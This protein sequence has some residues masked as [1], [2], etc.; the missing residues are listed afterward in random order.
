MLPKKILFFGTPSLA[1]PTLEALHQDAR[2]TVTGV[3][4]FPDRKVGRKQVLT[5]APL[6]VA[7]QALG[8]PIHEVAN[9]DDLRKVLGQSLKGQGCA[10]SEAEK[11]HPG[12]RTADDAAPEHI[13]KDTAPLPPKDDEPYGNTKPF[14]D[15]A[16]VIAFGMI[17]PPDV[18][19]L[20]PC[21]VLNVHF[22]LLPAYRGATPVQAAVRDGQSISGITLQRMVPALDAGDILWQAPYPIEGKKTSE[23]FTFFAQETAKNLLDVLHG[24]LEGRITPQPQDEAAATFCTTLRRE[25]ALLDTQSLCAREVMQRFLAY[26]IFPGVEIQTQYGRLKLKDISCA[27]LEGAVEL[28]C[29]GG[30]SVYIVRAQ[31]PGKKPAQMEDIVRGYPGILS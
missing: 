19:E 21:G 17:F 31:L 5:P 30:G 6:K 27:P 22:S 4:V 20:L 25:D 10:R 14:P 2:F 16:L 18:L 28:P 3:G 26:D 9:K 24:Y 7:A 12:G 8:I 29:G 11:M 15:M 13:C 1:I 23:L